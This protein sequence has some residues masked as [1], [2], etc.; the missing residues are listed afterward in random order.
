MPVVIVPRARVQADE[1]HSN[2][3]Q[4]H[5]HPVQGSGAQQEL[6][7]QEPTERRECLLFIEGEIPLG[8]MEHD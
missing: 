7:E 1:K 2:R 5:H 8:K 3:A 4:A 6:L